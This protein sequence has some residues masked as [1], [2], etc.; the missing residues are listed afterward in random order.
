MPTKTPNTICPECGTPF[1]YRSNKRFCSSKC[2]KAESR[3]AQRAD[4][5]VNATNRP[6]VR[7]EQHEVFELAQ[8]LAENLYSLPPSERLGYIEHLVQLARSGD[9]PTLR[10]IMTNPKFI[11][12][13]P[14]SRHLFWRGSSVYC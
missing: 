6:S 3:K 8:R 13:N 7:R 12:P 5:P 2:R 10:K 14:E 4:Q 11:Y 9:C 1:P